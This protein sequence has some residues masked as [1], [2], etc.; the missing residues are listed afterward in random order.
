[1]A[2]FDIKSAIANRLAQQGSAGA[3]GAVMPGAGGMP[4]IATILGLGGGAGPSM[5]QLV[6]DVGSMPKGPQAKPKGNPMDPRSLSGI[7][8]RGSNVYSGGLP[9]AQMGGGP[10]FG[11]PPTGAAG[12]M[13]P[14]IGR[15][16]GA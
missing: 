2:G 12:P 10:Q 7:M 14:A 4:D 9:Q 15:R 11:R 5:P 8:S 6:P 1:M 3:R 13:G 16:L